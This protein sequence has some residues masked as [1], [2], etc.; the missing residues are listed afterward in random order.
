MCEFYLQRHWKDRMEIA[1][2]GKWRKRN[3]W[4]VNK[5]CLDKVWSGWSDMDTRWCPREGEEWPDV[6]SCDHVLPGVTMDA[7]NRCILNCGGVRHETYKVNIN[8]L[9]L[10]HQL[11]DCPLT[12]T[13]LTVTFCLQWQSFSQDLDLLIL[14]IAGYIDTCLQWHFSLAPMVS[15]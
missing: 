10:I 11:Q 4:K 6:A 5:A 3:E 1:T 12:V 15:L 7:E 2:R 9:I 8:W 13:L 14:K